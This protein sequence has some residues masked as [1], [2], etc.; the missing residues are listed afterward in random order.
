MTFDQLNKIFTP[1]IK[2]GVELFG[3]LITHGGRGQTEYDDFLSHTWTERAIVHTI[4]LC[5]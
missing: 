2:E 3:E 5:L 1:E 4:F